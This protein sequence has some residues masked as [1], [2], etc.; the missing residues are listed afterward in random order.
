[1]RRHAAILPTLTLLFL[2]ASAF[3]ASGKIKLGMG[4]GSLNDRVFR[5]ENF[6][7]PIGYYETSTQLDSANIRNQLPRGTTWLHR[8]LNQNYVFFKMH[9][10]D[11]VGGQPDNWNSAFDWISGSYGAFV[12]GATDATLIRSGS[13]TTASP[14][15]LGLNLGN[16]NRWTARQ[17]FKSIL[18]DS[19]L[20][21]A[22]GNDG[23]TTIKA[24]TDLGAGESYTMFLPISAGKSGQFL[25]AFGSGLTG[26]TSAVTN[27]TTGG[28]LKRTISGATYT[29]GI[30][31]ANANTLTATQTFPKVVTDTALVKSATCNVQIIA[32][33]TDPGT[34]VALT[35]PPDDGDASEFLQT[36]GS[37]VMT[38][39]PEADGV[40]GNEVTGASADSILKR[41]GAGTTVAPYTLRFDTTRA[42]TLTNNFEVRDT[43]KMGDGT[44]YT[45]FETDGSMR[46][47]GNATVWD[48]LQITAN[49]LERPGGSDPEYVKWTPN[50]GGGGSIS[51]YLLEFQNGD[52]A[53]FVVQLP[54][55]YK[56][57]S[58]IYAHLH[59]TPGAAGS[60]EEGATVGWKI[61]Y[62]W[63]N[64]DGTF[65]SGAT[66]S[67]SD[68]CDGDDDK[69]QMTPEVEISG[70]GKTTSSMLVC[71]IKRTDTGTDDTWAGTASGALPMLL[72]IDF[73]YEMDTI[74][75]RGMSTK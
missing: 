8:R 27:V 73:H 32:P 65:G 21:K 48:E 58:S 50:L 7:V 4:V 51:M 26:W 23:I 5:L 19:V 44:N 31:Y 52:S 56:Q 66:V 36:N 57:G 54:H 34:N 64:I 69:H 40:I 61:D 11:I 43:V 6:T 15:T 33:T 60:D 72:E 62:T 2:T 30:N 46:M 38:W 18:S 17:T 25:G 14:Y 1:M 74:G 49:A 68:A 29:V 10:D 42:L 41:T 53:S 75:S 28:G 47:V 13:G 35:L 70:S 63:A 45:M 20:F 22:T 24:R 67:L 39:E 55:S 12:T 37:G 9:N 16:A 3:A 59:W 71:N